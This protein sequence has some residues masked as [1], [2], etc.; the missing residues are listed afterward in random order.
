MGGYVPQQHAPH[1]D[2]DA[3]RTPLESSSSAT[4]P[5][6]ADL[7]QRPAVQ[8]LIATQRASN[9]SPRV[10]TQARTAVNLARRGTVQ[11]EVTSRVPKP[12]SGD[13]IP[14]CSPLK[15]EDSKGS[16][17]LAALSDTQL[18]VGPGAAQYA[19][20]T[21]LKVSTSSGDPKP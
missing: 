8:R 18:G 5:G 13:D 16:R 14:S 19:T 11:R 7:N 9:R 6:L 20:V 17:A 3:S 15:S 12:T 21:Q 4:A 10:V 1:I 2:A